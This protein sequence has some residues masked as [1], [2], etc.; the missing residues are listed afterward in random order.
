[1]ANKKTSGKPF[2]VVTRGNVR[3]PGYRRKQRKNGT[4]FIEDPSP[5]L[6]LADI[7]QGRAVEERCERLD[8]LGLSFGGA[9]RH[10]V[11]IYVQPGTRRYWLPLRAELAN[12]R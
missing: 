4:L 7:A 12:L 6:A 3:V 5:A 9:D 1:M 8:V 2:F 11:P 10:C